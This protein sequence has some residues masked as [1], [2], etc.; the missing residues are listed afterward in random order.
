MV[1]CP[2]LSPIPCLLAGHS[3]SQKSHTFTEYI[4]LKPAAVSRTASLPPCPAP[5]KQQPHPPPQKGLKCFVKRTQNANRRA[6]SRILAIT[7]EAS[8]RDETQ[9]PSWPPYPSSRRF[10]GFQFLH[11]F[12]N[13]GTPFPGSVHKQLFNWMSVSSLTGRPRRTSL[14]LECHRNA[15][16][17]TRSVSSAQ[18]ST[19]R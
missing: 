13:N 19:S 14:P 18:H 10:P 6:A 4:Q 5:A 15:T 2:F 9:A 7:S 3:P 17:R 8:R 12:P 11:R 1:S 16:Y